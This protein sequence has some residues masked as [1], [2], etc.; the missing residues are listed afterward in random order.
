MMK[1]MFRIID[2]H[3]A[4]INLKCTKLHKKIK[5]KVILGAAKPSQ[6]YSCN[7]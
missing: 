1:M 6:C 3:A 7:Q 4:K 2:A 5:C